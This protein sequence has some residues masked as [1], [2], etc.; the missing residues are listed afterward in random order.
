MGYYK[1]L[2]VIFVILILSVIVQGSDLFSDAFFA[3]AYVI[4]GLVLFIGTKYERTSKTSNAI[5]LILIFSVAFLST[6]V[7][8]DFFANPP[9]VN[10]LF[11]LAIVFSLDACALFFLRYG[12]QF[13]KEEANE[14]RLDP[15]KTPT[16]ENLY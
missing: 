11:K 1:M 15:Y 10:T 3:I 9:T 14:H 2:A 7:L 5:G 8:I 12:K 16:K 6:L 4:M 13:K